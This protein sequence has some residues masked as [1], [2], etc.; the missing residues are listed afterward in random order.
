MSSIT[1]RRPVLESQQKSQVT[2]YSVSR[3]VEYFQFYWT[4]TRGTEVEDDERKTS[5]V[6]SVLKEEQGG[7]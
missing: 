4:R 6:R 1:M 2:S 3:S 7:W 5:E